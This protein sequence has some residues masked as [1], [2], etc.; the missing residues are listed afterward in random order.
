[1]E[2][3]SQD[4][5]PKTE[6]PSPFPSNVTEGRP[7]PLRRTRTSQSIETQLLGASGP[8]D[9]L[10]LVGQTGRKMDAENV[11]L[12]LLRLSDTPLKTVEPP[13]TDE[14]HHQKASFPLLTLFRLQR[15]E[16]GHPP[17]FL[18]SS[19][20][21]SKRTAEKL[22]MS[23][24]ETMIA[25]LQQLHSDVFHVA[26]RMPTE[27]QAVYLLGVARSLCAL[28]FGPDSPAPLAVFSRTA[29]VTAVRA[30][31]GVASRAAALLTLTSA[32][33]GVGQS[34]QTING[35]A[36]TAD[37]GDALW[38]VDLLRCLERC[39][40][41]GEKKGRLLDAVAERG[42]AGFGTGGTW[43]FCVWDKR[44]VLQLFVCMSRALR[45]Y[46]SEALP[47]AA[48]VNPHKGV[49]WGGGAGEGF[50]NGEG[51][52]QRGG[53]GGDDEE[54]ENAGAY[55]FE[56]AGHAGDRDWVAWGMCLQ[57]LASRLVLRF[58]GGK[59]GQS[60]A[61]GLSVSEAA[62]FLQGVVAVKRVWW[63][64]GG[65]SRRVM[66]ASLEKVVEE[67][68]R[69]KTHRE[70]EGEE[71]A[72][73]M[74]EREMGG[75]PPVS[76]LDE[77]AEC[78]LCVLT[79]LA[80]RVGEIESVGGRERDFLLATLLESLA[81]VSDFVRLSEEADSQVTQKGLHATDTPLVRQ[82]AY[83][84]RL[85]KKLERLLCTPEQST[86]E[87][88]H[89]S[90][91]EGG[92]KEPLNVDRF[93]VSRAVSALSAF[94]PA[95]SSTPLDSPVIDG[96]DQGSESPDC[97]SVRL[98][99]RLL[100]AVEEGGGLR[101]SSLFSISNLTVAASSALQ[102]YSACETE[103]GS[104]GDARV[105]GEIAV[106]LR[107]FLLRC[108]RELRRRMGTRER[109]RGGG[110]LLSTRDE[111]AARRAC[112]ALRECGLVDDEFVSLLWSEIC[113]VRGLTAEG[114]G[115]KVDVEGLGEVSRDAEGG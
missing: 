27:R 16:I 82:R 65:M 75:I 45:E 49:G 23:N 92:R 88:A 28:G 74:F 77:C 13:T 95:R 53:V 78:A 106:G 97:P 113:A 107:Q 30:L 70:G 85:A 10:T 19:N 109:G 34:D 67:E 90:E 29:N 98:L 72:V 102:W 100:H 41:V 17:D 93:T 110:L 21:S 73:V 108:L 14:P 89:S 5:S 111:A 50:E 24:R 47:S 22:L 55:S 80:D 4:L 48:F 86:D 44:D 15:E 25:L 1:M 115:G 66:K 64:E 32:D 57:H 79:D 114:V 11:V 59:E 42:V 63:R 71:E 62:E 76:L 69:E 20:S 105:D 18:H 39:G 112:G 84:N 61:R 103:G 9:V 6:D 37:V 26:H 60:V 38:V 52:R 91:C 46:E 40:M 83:V 99:I 35:D 3:G 68:N 104:V 36:L 81:S 87:L 51:V 96:T 12:V 8:A 58:C 56:E 7:P 43:D 33:V 54:N 2:M 31:N 101:S 94:L